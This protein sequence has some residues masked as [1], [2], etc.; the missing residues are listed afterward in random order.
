MKSPDQIDIKS[1][2]TKNFHLLRQIASKH[3]GDCLESK[4]INKQ[5]KYRFQCK[6]GH[7]WWAPSHHIK[8][9]T[10][11]KICRQ[12]EN[13]LKRRTP[14]EFF[15]ALAITK[16]GECISD[17]WAP[18][19]KFKCKDG[20]IWS[21]HKSTIQSGAWCKIC[22]GIRGQ[23]YKKDN[24][25]IFKNIIEQKGGKLMTSEYK[26]AAESRLL[27][28]CGK[29]HQWLA[30][31]GHLKK[32]LWCRK[33]NGSFR[34][35]LSDVIKLAKSRAGKCLST[36][37]KNDMTSITWQCSEKHIWD[38]TPNN[39]KRGKWCPTCVS[40]IGERICRLTF[41][42]IFDSHFNKVR[43]KWLRNKSGF[44][45]ELDGY[46]K[47]LR[48]AFE[49]QGMQHYGKKTNSRFYTTSIIENDKQKKQICETNGVTV[50]YIPEV[51]KYTELNNL[52]SFIL[53][54][55]DK[56]NFPYPKI[57]R[58]I[59]LD[60]REVYTSSKTKDVEIRE[61]RALD[62]LKKNNAIAINIRR[63]N[64]GVFLKIKCSKGH[65]LTTTF[66]AILSGHIC[67]KCDDE[68][69]QK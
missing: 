59:I 19:L 34:H 27:V 31:P 62:I 45:L 57:A 63:L 51:F 2:K 29:G 58:E 69:Q 52:V 22:S 20:H 11:C 48:L 9:G 67:K 5:S 43:P 23:A 35:E 1:Q 32:G 28:E 26:N 55:L 64:S 66:N 6:E 65:E 36:V 60:P 16:G 18:Y 15:K 50:I 33:C 41:E 46:N 53:D 42:K 49:H 30:Y 3:G 44:P 13:G 38:A 4:I 21:T 12:K 25:D 24:I 14:I 37:Y 61:K 7:F 54:E 68:Q 56:H 17:S 39:I 8:K 10:W 40:G 47:N